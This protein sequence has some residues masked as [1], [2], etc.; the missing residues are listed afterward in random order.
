MAKRAGGSEASSPGPAEPAYTLEEPVERNIQGQRPVVFSIGS[1]PNL[2][3]S[4]GAN[5]PGV[6]VAGLNRNSNSGTLI[7]R[8]RSY[9]CDCGDSCKDSSCCAQSRHERTECRF[10]VLFG[11]WNNSRWPL[12]HRAV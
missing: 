10:W 9:T 7:A 3:A 5:R 4:T 6:N 1:N 12:P 11:R 8:V 2:L